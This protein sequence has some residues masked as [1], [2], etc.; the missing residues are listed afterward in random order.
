M[1]MSYAPSESIKSAHYNPRKGRRN[2]LFQIRTAVAAVRAIAQFYSPF[3]A[4]VMTTKT[5]GVLFYLKSRGGEN[6]GTRDVY[7]RITVNRR[8]QEISLQRKCPVEDW[9]QAAGRMIGRQEKARALN[10]YLDT[11][12]AKVHEARHQL[13]QLGRPITAA[14]IR[15]II[16]GKDPRSEE[17]HML[18]ETFS[19]HNKEVQELVGKGYAPGTLTR[20]KTAWKHTH[21]YIRD[22]YQVEDIDVRNLDYAFVDGFKHWLRTVKNCNHNTTM[23][24]IAC[25]K[26]IV[27]RCI[28]Y[29]WIQLDPFNGFSMGLHEVH[30]EVLT[31]E[32]LQTLAAKEFPVARVAQ[33]RDIFLFSCYTGLAYIDIRQLTRASI[34]I[35]VDGGK[36][37]FTQRQKTDVPSR[38]PLLPQALNILARYEHHPASERRGL[39]LP[40]L[41]NQKMNAYLKEIADL[42]GI[43]KH[44]TFHIARHTFATTVTLSN[45]VPIETVSKILGHTNLKTTQHYA[46]ILDVKVSQDMQALRRKLEAQAEQNQAPDN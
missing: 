39:A 12:E 35:G 1:R 4:I 17:K 45:G 25:C 33:V 16:R 29:G 27:R 22:T 36:W 3:N 46:K 38:I 15:D 20:F 28:R 8:I 23:K 30:R 14:L 11:V 41:S 6:K 7:L 10:A 24:F 31:K 18:L 43:Q 34:A 5:F 13:L 40:V 37:I 9:N 42:C 44:L 2:G 32:E 21:A 26:K 19:K